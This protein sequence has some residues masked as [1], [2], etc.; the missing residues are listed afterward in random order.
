MTCNKIAIKTQKQNRIGGRGQYVGTATALQQLLDIRCGGSVGQR[1]VT[2]PM[3]EKSMEVPGFS[4]LDI[5][6]NELEDVGV[7]IAVSV[8]QVKHWAAAGRLRAD[9][10]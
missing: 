10:K 9:K 6:G 3:K 4:S 8:L 1:S 5:C 7:R 2:A